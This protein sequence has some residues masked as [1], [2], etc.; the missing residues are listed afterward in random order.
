MRH[1]ASGLLDRTSV[2]FARCGRVLVGVAVVATIAVVQSSSAVASTAARQTIE[3]FGDS[4]S[5][6]A[7]P[8]LERDF[9]KVTVVNETH[10][11]PGTSVC[12][13]LPAIGK[14]T[15]K[16]A[17]Q[18]VVLQFIGNVSA[19][20]HAVTAS[21]ALAA[22]YAAD[23]TT[24]ITELRADGVGDVAVDEGPQTDCTAFAYCAAQPD[25]RAAFE[26][27]V[28]SFDTPG[29]VYT[30]LA[31]HEVET[32]T[33]QF[34]RWLTCLPAEVRAKLCKAGS[35]MRVRAADGIHFRPLPREIHGAKLLYDSGA[36][37]FATGFAE[38]IWQLDP[39]TMPK[40]A[41]TIP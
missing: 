33:G 16:D 15:S 32:P 17:P 30:Y 22:A 31:D 20:D 23:L 6:Q 7:S 34:T 26:R 11:F 4:L 39:A 38:I 10:V 35:K 29:V 28:G 41:A 2:S 8:Y 1:T 21:L 25:L 5:T 12:D 9:S 36:Y 13:W 3:V 27:V 14:L 18:V 40:G 24:A 19:C 37:R